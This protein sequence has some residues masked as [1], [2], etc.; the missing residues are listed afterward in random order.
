MP[1]SSRT[2]LWPVSGPENEVCVSVAEGG[3]GAMSERP[4]SPGS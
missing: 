4:G 3:L 2:V 1:R